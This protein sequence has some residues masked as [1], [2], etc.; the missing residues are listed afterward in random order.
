MSQTHTSTYPV[1]GPPR[2]VLPRLIG[3]IAVSATIGLAINSAIKYFSPV[4]TSKAMVAVREQAMGGSGNAS[5]LEL[6]AA[7]G[8]ALAAN[9]EVLRRA[10]ENPE[11][12]KTDFAAQF[13]TSEGAFKGSEALIRLREG[14][15][16]EPLP[17]TRLFR[18][19]FSTR[20][21][22]DAPVILNAVIDGLCRLQQDFAQAQFDRQHHKWRQTCQELD[23]VIAQEGDRMRD[24]IRSN[25]LTSADPD[26][27]DMLAP[28]QQANADLAQN[29]A[30]LGAARSRVLQAQ[31]LVDEDRSPRLVLLQR[32]D[33]DPVL[34][35]L[36]Q[37]ANEAQRRFEAANLSGSA[38]SA[39]LRVE[40]DAA[41]TVLA[42]VRQERASRLAMADLRE[43][44][45]EEESLAREVKRQEES[46]VSLRRLA[47]D[48]AESLMALR[49]MQDR[50]DELRR[51]R[52]EAAQEMGQIEFAQAAGPVGSFEIVQAA[53]EPE[54]ITWPRIRYTVPVTVIAIVIGWFML[55][56][57]RR[58]A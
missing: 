3:M 25:G 45:D 49:K 11:V 56:I 5:L 22:E 33:A 42:D 6:E 40:A 48:R 26:T 10:L 17:G 4:W 1:P 52:D 15:Q 38:D 29:F 7:T 57:I 51:R 8:A 53:R 14:L 47:S 16:A 35:G 30:Q 54:R 32:L 27:N 39:K 20:V 55:A 13:V 41:A 34:V 44:T 21:P 23:L 9:D 31:R 12:R 43:A 37:S 50:L 46:V 19:Q 58:L 18:V 24:F 2:P 28:L 36:Q